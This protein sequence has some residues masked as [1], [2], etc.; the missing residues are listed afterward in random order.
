MFKR[1]KSSKEE[2]E[3]CRLIFAIIGC[4]A[5]GYDV[6]KTADLLKV[7]IFQVYTTYQLI[8]ENRINFNFK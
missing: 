4:H 1:K 2:V 5:M 7:N 6:V 8:D 3:G